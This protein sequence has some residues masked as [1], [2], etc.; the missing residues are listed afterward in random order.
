MHGTPRAAITALQR[1]AGSL[2]RK[3]RF[4]HRQQIFRIFVHTRQ[5]STRQCQR[6]HRNEDHELAA[7]SSIAVGESA[8][9]AM[10]VSALAMCGLSDVS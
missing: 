4:E 7:R 10:A 5:L 3:L 6:V 8:M 2:C 1:A 9:F